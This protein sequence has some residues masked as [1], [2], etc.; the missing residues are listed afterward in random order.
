MAGR[1]VVPF[2]DMCFII[3]LPLL[4]F[5][6]SNS[7]HGVSGSH[8]NCIVLPNPP[9][10]GVING[11]YGEIV[12]VLTCPDGQDVPLTSRA[13]GVLRCNPLKK[14]YAFRDVRKHNCLPLKRPDGFDMFL[15]LAY[16]KE[17]G[18]CT[19][20]ESN[21]LSSSVKNVLLTVK[22][23]GQIRGLANFLN[24]LRAK[25][26]EPVVKCQNKGKGN[27]LLSA[28]VVF[29]ISPYKHG[30]SIESYN[31]LAKHIRNRVDAYGQQSKVWRISGGF[32]FESV[33]MSSMY[34]S[35]DKHPYTSGTDL[36]LT[37]IASCRGC[38][39]DYIM[40]AIHSG[41]CEF[42]GVMMY[43]S[44]PFARKCLRCPHPSTNG[45][46]KDTEA[47]YELLCVKYQ[48]DYN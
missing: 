18:S 35:C 23:I 42:C 25:W 3:L 20:A 10:N 22:M 29:K 27:S 8:I 31:K 7:P 17:N 9:V 32:Y 11:P 1:I 24:K 21:R 19:K 26:L 15:S 38:P 2:D 34:S 33:N 41:V 4:V 14:T 16:K 43:T 6:H 36:S 39:Q 30:Q 12:A 40:S 5:F 46:W 37:H 45:R 28:D 48:P 47:N 44:G 13:G